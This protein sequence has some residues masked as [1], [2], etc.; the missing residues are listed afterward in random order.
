MKQFEKATGRKLNTLVMIGLIMVL[1]PVNTALVMFI[2]WLFRSNEYTDVSSFEGLS[3]V[4]IEFSLPESL[5]F[6]GLAVFMCGL[7]ILGYAAVRRFLQK[8]PNKE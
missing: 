5:P 4:Y 6:I 1:V 7:I 2:F 8:T 3:T